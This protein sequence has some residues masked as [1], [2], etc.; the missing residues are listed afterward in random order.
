MLPENV[1]SDSALD[2]Q[3]DMIHGRSPEQDLHT[4][5]TYCWYTDIRCLRYTLDVW[6][7]D[8]DTFG[9]YPLALQRLF[10][11]KMRHVYVHLHSLQ[12]IIYIIYIIYM[13]KS[14]KELPTWRCGLCFSPGPSIPSAK[15]LHCQSQGPGHD[16]D[17]IEDVSNTTIMCFIYW[18]QQKSTNCSKSRY[19]CLSAYI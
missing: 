9:G 18:D 6:P 12:I 11:C 4:L 17:C 10:K 3:Q 19:V 16:L 8:L 5:A 14:Y 7:G 13:I 15:L 1:S 2:L